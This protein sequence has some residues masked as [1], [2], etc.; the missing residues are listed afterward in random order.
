MSAIAFGVLAGGLAGHAAEQPLS[1][2]SSTAIKD[3]YHFS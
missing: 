1:A 2:S 3:A